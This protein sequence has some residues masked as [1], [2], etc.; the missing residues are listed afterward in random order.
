MSAVQ[1]EV[2]PKPVAP[3]VQGLNARARRRERW[4]ALAVTVGPFLGFLAAAGLVAARG[5]RP[6]ELVLLVVAH[7]LGMVGISVSLH[8]YF[9]HGSFQT[10]RPV[11]LVL[12][13]LGSMAAQGPVL[14]W[15]ANHRRHHSHSDEPGDPH[16]P[17]VGRGGGP[18]GALRALWHAHMGWVF[19]HEI[20]EPGR[21]IPDLLRDPWLVRANRHY[22][23]WVLLGLALPA[24]AGGAWTGTWAGAGLGL[25]WGGL[26]RIFL[27]QQSVACINSV[28]HVWGSTPFRGGGQS[29]NNAL[30]AIASLGEGWHNN[31][32]A[33][34]YAAV[35]GLRWWQVDPLGWLVR[36]LAVVGVV[37]N[38]KAPTPA[39]VLAAVR[40]SEGDA[41]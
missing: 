22:F 1:A 13:V 37:W 27:G 12:L 20:A 8:R 18:L 34:P 33:F 30:V 41:A 17:H 35:F 31:H 26:V 11:R 38:V 19:E 28:C 40:T 32:H 29:R 9:S 7:V 10:S 2:L 5:L 3:G 25:I 39:S 14:Y 24:A 15:A 36:G 6:W 4:V 23:T 21:Y 16:S